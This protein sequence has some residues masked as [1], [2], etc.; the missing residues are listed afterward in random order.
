MAFVNVIRFPRIMRNTIPMSSQLLFLSVY[1]VTLVAFTHLAIRVVIA[2]DGDFV[3]IFEI[4]KS[5]HWVAIIVSWAYFY[6]GFG[7]PIMFIAAAI[8]IAISVMSEMPT[9]R[10]HN[11][12]YVPHRPITV[13]P[14]SSDTAKAA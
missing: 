8:L 7:S 2:A 14:R 9:R 12:L 11:Y 5:L 1:S 4:T 6:I 10:A 3:R 13:L